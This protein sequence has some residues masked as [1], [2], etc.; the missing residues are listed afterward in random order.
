MSF[1]QGKKI[2]VKAILN[3]ILGNGTLKFSSKGIFK[4]SP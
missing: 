2:E 1:F 4:K 3:Y